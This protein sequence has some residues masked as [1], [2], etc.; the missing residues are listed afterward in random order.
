MFGQN[1]Q[2]TRNAPNETKIGPGNA[3]QLATKWTFITGGDVSATAAT[4]GVTVYF[5]DWSGNLFAVDAATGLLRW[6]RP[7]AVYTGLPGSISR[8]S[9][10]IVGNTLLVGTQTGAYLLAID[11]RNGNLLWKTQVDTHTAAVITQSPVAAGGRVFVGVAS[12][13]EAL[14]ASTAYPCCTFRGS[15]LSLDFATG[16]ILWKTRTVPL[17]YS[18]G[19]VW[20]SSPVVDTRRRTVYVG[21]GNNYTVPEEVKRCANNNPQQ[22]GNCL[23]PNDYIDA[24]LALDIDTGRIKWGRR[25][26]GYDAWTAACLGLPP[27]VTWCPGPMG[28]DY[29]FGSGPNMFTVMLNGAPRDL[30]GA[31]QKSGIYWAL[32]PDTGAIVWNTLVGP[33]SSLGGI[34]WGSATDGQRIYAAIS[35]F[36]HKSYQLQPSGQTIDWGSFSALDAATGRLLWQIPDPVQG[37][38]DI[39]PVSVANGVAY[40]CSAD[41]VGHMYALEAATGRL[42]WSFASG[43]SCNSGA[44]IVN[45]SVYWGSGYVQSAPGTPNNKFYAFSV[46]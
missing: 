10:A 21:T 34:Q 11:R 4:D 42:L 17:G 37:S 28:P 23:A 30:L 22:A 24:V 26:Q 6:T 43:G 33:G 19:A 31:G 13:E 45:G 46:P 3:A 32:D 36:D 38:I 14:A 41:T 9:P 1:L 40:F 39:A 5:P 15:M 7:I 20:G 16:A 27:G 35:N 18:G 12:L 29:D 44:A 8:T 25:L 2:N